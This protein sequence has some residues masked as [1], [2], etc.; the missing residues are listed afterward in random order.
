MLPPRLIAP[1]LI[2]GLSELAPH[3]DALICDIWGVVHDGQAVFAAA[4]QALARFR[5]E[6]GP[7]VLLT[8][9]PRTPESVI[10]QFETIGVP[11]DC[12]DA[13]VTSGGAARD[14][15]AVLAARQGPV[16][17]YYIGPERDATLFEGL[18]IMRTDIA[19]AEIAL[20]TGLV[21]DLTETPDQYAAIL[22]AMRAEDLPMICANP[23]LKVHRGPQLCW[24]AGALARDYEKLRGDV[25]YY[26]KPR[27]PIYDVARAA[28]SS[29]GSGSS[30]EG[31]AAPR[32][33]AI[34]DGLITD[35]RGANAAGLDVLF[36]ADGVHGEEV[37]P[38][39]QEH[40]AELFASVNVH[41]LAATRALKW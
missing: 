34:G 4:A 39:T 28:I 29:A 18:G 40:L 30:P 5:Q 37:E 31:G 10:T 23:D 8:N 35:I 7:V 25:I 41:A 27:L 33:L 17:L 38:Y 15:L 13:I 9:A 1:R 20:C 21:D 6:R 22:A 19:G 2:S 14:H 16:P 36:I 3:Y 24:C 32:I 12:Y 26:G 11:A